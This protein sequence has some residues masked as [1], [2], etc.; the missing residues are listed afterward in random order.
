MS[1]YF[2]TLTAIGDNNIAN[3]LAFGK[4]VD[5]T[6][7]AVGDGTGDGAQGTP[8]PDPSATA[9]VSEQRRASLNSLKTDD[10]NA[11]VLIAEQVIPADVGGWW[12]RELGLYDAD[13]DLVAIANAPPTYKPE[14]SSGTGRTQVVRMQIVVS[15][16]SAVT[17]KI[18]PS[19]VL[20]TREYV[21]DAIDVYAT[22]T[23]KG[24]VELATQ[25]ETDTGK[26]KKRVITTDKLAA[27][28]RVLGQTHN[29]DPN[30]AVA[31]DYVFELCWD[32]SASPPISFYATAADGTAAGTTWQRLFAAFAGDTGQSFSV[33]DATQDTQAVALGQFGYDFS[34][35]GYTKLPNGLIIQWGGAVQPN[36]DNIFS[37]TLPIAFPNVLFRVF[38]TDNNTTDTGAQPVTV[39][40]N[41]C[42]LSKLYFSTIYENRIALFNYMAIG[43]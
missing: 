34:K 19:I 41:L 28:S 18:D 5:I 33:A 37:T 12:I 43:Y 36:Q 25:A 32:T 40:S 26:D 6:Q 27:S 10:A 4:T 23:K 20:A 30:G 29:G 7:M 42:T 9:L 17:L 14:L 31:A 16:T 2:A 3:A 1:D 24:R 13:G 38:A 11:N 39:R 22:T 35:I 15:D 8:V 21:D